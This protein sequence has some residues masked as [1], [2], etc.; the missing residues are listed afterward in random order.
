MNNFTFCSPTRF[1]FGGDV[2]DSVGAELAAAG[3]TRALIV[4]GQGSVVRTGTL[5]RVKSSLDAAGIPFVELGGVR[6]NPEIGLVRT[7]CELARAERVDVVLPVGGGSA[8]DC[9]KAIA[10]GRHA[11]GRPVG[12]LD[13]GGAARARPAHRHRG[14]H[15]RLRLRGLELLRDQQR[16]TRL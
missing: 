7:G 13:G 2:T 10:L 16:R 12:F 15:P 3:F 5:D 11:R 4:Y 1:I 14:D 6:P 8:M 9:A